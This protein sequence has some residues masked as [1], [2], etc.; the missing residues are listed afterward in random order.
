MIKLGQMLKSKKLL[1]VGIILVAGVVGFGV[2]QKINQGRTASSLPPINIPQITTEEYSVETTFGQ[3]DFKFPD[4]ISVLEKK[5]AIYTDEEVKT[6]AEKLGFTSSPQKTKDTLEGDMIIY[7]NQKAYL[8]AILA[9]GRIEYQLNSRP[10]VVNKEFSDPE[11][12]KIAT[13]FISQKGL[14]NEPI[15]FSSFVYLKAQEP[16]GIRTAAKNEA[17][18]YQLNFNPTVSSFDVIT[19]NP[20]ASPVSVKL[21]PDGSVY[22][23]VVTKLGTVTESTDK[24]KLKNFLEVTTSIKNKEAVLITLDQGNLS[25]SDLTS[26]ALA[27]ITFSQISLAYLELGDPSLLYPVFVLSGSAQI[28]GRSNEVPAVAYLPAISAN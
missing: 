6:I 25:P 14:S 1:L 16:E 7:S 22:G 17:S 15:K 3:K 9:K 28:S 8:L 23:T 27:K 21:L 24:F 26:G 2:Y 11:L 19:L 12:I 4:K 18:F 5:S 10:A 13:D 20:L